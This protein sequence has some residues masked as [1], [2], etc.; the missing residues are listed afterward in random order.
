MEMGK[1]DLITVADWG[2]PIISIKTPAN[3]YQK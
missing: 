2:K 3:D 1:K